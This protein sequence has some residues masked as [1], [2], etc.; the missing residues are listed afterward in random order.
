MI[1]IIDV[2]TGKATIFR[3]SSRFLG[4][5]EAYFLQW[6]TIRNEKALKSSLLEESALD[7]APLLQFLLSQ[8]NKEI[9]NVFSNPRFTIFS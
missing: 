5:H 6:G 2:A 4:F 3:G 1:G 7:V 8:T 9:Y